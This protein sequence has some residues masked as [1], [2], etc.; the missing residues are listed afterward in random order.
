MFKS[1]I[2]E[3]IK[4][5]NDSISNRNY[6]IEIESTVIEIEFYKNINRKSEPILI[7]M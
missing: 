7:K 1:I 6:S 5:R 3:V 4:I 2:Q